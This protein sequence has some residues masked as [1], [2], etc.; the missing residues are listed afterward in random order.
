MSR[1]V[2]ESTSDIVHTC[3]HAWGPHK[4]ARQADRQTR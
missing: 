3:T 2:T 4:T 1:D